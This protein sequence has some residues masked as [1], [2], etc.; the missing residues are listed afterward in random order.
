MEF[1]YRKGFTSGGVY[2]PQR[3]YLWW[4][5]CTVKDVPLVEFMYR[6]GCTS[7]GVYVPCMPG[8]S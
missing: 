3:M 4:S 1:T 8:E 7:G 5:L 6:T 2:V